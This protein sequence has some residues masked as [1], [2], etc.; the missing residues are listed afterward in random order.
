M[1]EKSKPTAAAERLQSLP[2]RPGPGILKKSSSSLQPV[3]EFAESKIQR[4][5]SNLETV[6]SERTSTPHA[7]T[8]KDTV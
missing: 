1:V 7:R 4:A 5:D 3:P 2:K 6:E 8:A